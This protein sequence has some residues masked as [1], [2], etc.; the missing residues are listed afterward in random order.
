LAGGAREAPPIRR[1]VLS[2]VWHVGCDGHQSDNGWIHPSFG[3]YGSPI[4]MSDKNARSVLKSEGPLGG[5]HV[6]FKRRLRL[7]NDA[8]VV[9]ILHKDVVN[10]FPPGTICPSAVNQNN[11]SNGM[12]LVFR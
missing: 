4:A 7:L 8:D 6:V 1:P 5:S 3:N 11:I 9:A 12:L 2:S 10:A